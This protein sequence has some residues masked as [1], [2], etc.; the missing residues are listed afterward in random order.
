MFRST[1]GKP[2][3]RADGTMALTIK[4]LECR[5]NAADLLETDISCVASAGPAAVRTRNYTRCAVPA[6][7]PPSS[8]RPTQD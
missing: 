6:G 3:S 2:A 5:G 8:D 4:L 1:L 7:G